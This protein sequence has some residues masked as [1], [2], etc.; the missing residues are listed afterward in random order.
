MNWLS[1]TV[2]SVVLG[3]SLVAPM[4]VTPQADAN[5]TSQTQHRVYYVYYRSCS[6]TPWVCYGGYYQPNQAQQ[7]VTWFRYYGYDS[8][9]R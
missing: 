9:Y 5:P 8:Y 3:L 4:A 1:K 2:V 7:A 6:S